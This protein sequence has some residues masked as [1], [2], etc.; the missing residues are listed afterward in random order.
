[1]QEQGFLPSSGGC[2]PLAHSLLLQHRTC[3]WVFVCLM[4]VSLWFPMC[5]ILYVYLRLDLFA[6]MKT[7]RLGLVSIVLK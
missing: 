1:M 4:G 2:F 7:V 5:L 6:W 3:F